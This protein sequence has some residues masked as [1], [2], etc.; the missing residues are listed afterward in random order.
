[1]P[2]VELCTPM[3]TIVN[4]LMRTATTPGIPMNGT[5]MVAMS[6]HTATRGIAME[7]LRTPTAGGYRSR[8][9]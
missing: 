3:V 5:A 2:T 7:W 8:W 4:T 6:T 9:G 1:M